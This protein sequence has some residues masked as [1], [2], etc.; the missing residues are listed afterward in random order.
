M[1]DVVNEAH[2]ELLGFANKLKEY[3]GVSYLPRELIDDSENRVDFSKRTEDELLLAHFNEDSLTSIKTV[4]FLKDFSRYKA[5]PDKKTTNK[6]FI[7]T[8][9]VF[10]QQGVKNYFFLLQLNNPALVGVDPYDPNLTSE[11]MLMIHEESRT[12]FWYFLREVCRLKPEQPFMAN[13]GNIS[14]IW[15]Y[16]NHITTY[17]I[18]PRQQGKMQ[19]NSS[20]VRVKPENVLTNLTPKDTWK[21]IGDLRTGDVVIDRFGQEA[22]VIG[23]HP[24]GK[25]RMYRVT[26][27]DGRYTDVGTEHLW[28]I[29]DLGRG[30]ASTTGIWDD[31]S[32]AQLIQMLKERRVMEIPLVVPE[33]GVKQ[34]LKLDPYLLG[35]L[36]AATPVDNKL[37]FVV[38]SKEQVE[39][40]VSNLPEEMLITIEGNAGF[41]SK[42]DNSPLVIN[43]DLGFQQE[44]LEGHLNDRRGLLQGF[45]DQRLELGR[46]LYLDAPSKLI[47]K[48]LSYLVR[49]LG[50]TARLTQKRLE[51]TLPL[52]EEG[53]SVSQHYYRFFEPIGMIPTSNHLFIDSIRY[54]G[55]D[56]ATCIEVDAQDHLYITDDFIVTHN[57]VSVQ[58]INFWLT[59]I[60]GRGYKSH[61]ITLKSDNR[62]Q[63]I[64][65]IKKIRTCLPKYLVNP[66]WKDKDAGNYLTYKAFGEEH[67]NTLT[68]SVPQIGRDAAGDLGRGLTVETTTYDEPAY[69]NF[70]EE[71]INGCAPSALTA[72]ENARKAGKPYGISYIT[73]PNT[74]LHPSGNFMFEKLMS[75]TEWRE[76]FFDSYSESHLRERLLKASP[77]Q[78]TSPSVSMVYNYLQLGKDKDWVKK[79]IDSLS[80]SL[81]K[82][83]IDLLLMWV[84]DGENRLFDD[85]TREAINNVK[86]PVVW[87]KEYKSSGLFV[88]FFV[89]QSELIEMGKKSYNDFFVIGMDTSSAINKDACTLIIRSI[90]TGKVIGVGRY[91]LAF[92]DDVTAIFVDMLQTFENSVLIPERNYAHHMIDS[93]LILL[94]A[95]GMDP[96][97]RIYNQV[98]QDPV[99]HVKELEAVRLTKFSYRDKNFYLKY[100]Q[101]F[102]FNTTAK[103][104]EVLYGLI[105]EAVGITGYGIAYDKLADEL[106]GLRTKGGRI[107]HDSKQH[108]DLVISWLLTYWFIKLGANKSYYNVPPG[109]ALTDTRNL[110]FAGKEKTDQYVDPNVVKMLD[111]VRGK[112]NTMTQELL[113][114]NDNI[115]AMRLEAEIRKLSKLL[116]PETHK[117]VTLDNL[118]EEA[119]MERGKRML[120]AR[121]AR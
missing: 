14:F 13:R 37:R 69:I 75:A 99:N 11:Q 46:V 42:R 32:T 100:K 15:N 97:E 94:P 103:S 9:E 111:F 114:T 66:T 52:A 77:K 10:R 31:Y 33:V 98:Y 80:L 41:I 91:P 55:E 7:R 20:K 72:M 105:Q 60:N 102:G 56:E 29:R 95:R 34:K 65:A 92:L 106:I 35:T 82:A 89:P 3:L 113:K 70:I 27:T 79:T 24:H 117:L 76:K 45:F 21:K 57:T 22:N 2:Q 6:S 30:T 71:I 107:D 109:V 4:R 86:R 88:D 78:T 81:S 47:G 115:L 121:M 5:A 18:M 90:K 17:M 58:V 118:I 73:T 59:Y 83:K 93:L 64:D 96:F 62:A 26:M 116:P 44:Y 63:F 12:N 49:S 25:K 8:A 38:H 48:Q 54:M 87:S 61:L 110:L 108:D 23:I 84:E 104:R 67:V 28:T 50:G 112:I 68:I 51:V 119:K 101:Y 120:K 85:V 19:R 39:Y 40:L 43:H 36:V 1:S 53:E 16:L 74:S